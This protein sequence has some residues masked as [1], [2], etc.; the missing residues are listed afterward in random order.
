MRHIRLGTLRLDSIFF[1]MVD[2]LLKD[3]RGDEPR[4]MR[5]GRMR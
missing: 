5:P 2:R 1:A 4:M 3:E